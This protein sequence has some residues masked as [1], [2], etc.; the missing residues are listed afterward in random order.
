M[1]KYIFERSKT[2]GCSFNYK[3]DKSRWSM[4]F[5][6]NFLEECHKLLNINY[7]GEGMRM[8]K[9]KRERGGNTKLEIYLSKVYLIRSTNPQKH[10]QK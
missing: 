5:R 1:R 3:F 7:L 8:R 4:E 6:E 9:K 10:C 2:I